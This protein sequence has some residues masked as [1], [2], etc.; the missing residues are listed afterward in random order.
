MNNISLIKRLGIGACALLATFMLHAVAQPKFTLVPMTPTT[1]SLN[2][3][4]TAVVQ[5]RVTNQT[6]ITRTLTIMPIAGITQITTPTLLVPNLECPNPFTLASMQSCLLTLEL[7]GSS[8]PD[9]VTNGP[10]VC[11][12]QGPGNNSPDPILCS[13]PSQADSLNITLLGGTSNP[14]RSIA[15]TPANSTI[16][17]GAPQQFTATGTYA[18]GATLNLTELVTWSSSNTSV[19]TASNVTPYIGQA[20][21]VSSGSVAITATLGAVSGSTT[22][23]VSAAIVP[24]S[25][26]VTPANSTINAITAG[27]STTQQFTATATF[28]DASVHDVTNLS[29]W[30]SS[31]LEAAIINSTTGLATARNSGGPTT[32]TATYSIVLGFTTLNVTAANIG[33]AYQGGVLACLA[34]PEFENLIAATSDDGAGTPLPWAIIGGDVAGATSAT[35]GAANTIAIVSAE[36]AGTTYSAGACDAYTSGG[37]NDWYLPAINEVVGC[38][39]FHRLAIGG[40]DI[41]TSYW[42][43]TQDT[44]LNAFAVD[45]GTGAPVST[46]KTLPFK[47]RCVR[48]PT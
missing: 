42:S 47:L 37:Y 27:E 43:S 12:T 23:T 34:P 15:V 30:S 20:V 48:K 25:L 31:V 21:G 14:L 36:G 8:L 2:P 7:N 17:V 33:D 16:G 9:R 41:S 26:V 38:L 45:F 4:D 44:I 32:I 3:T 39:Y 18:S 10:V 19:A 22:L 40:F 28:S 1:L 24:I 11:K 29:T 6:N 35:D 5:Y 13:Q 46:V